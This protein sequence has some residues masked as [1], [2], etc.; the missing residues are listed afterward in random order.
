MFSNRRFLQRAQANTFLASEWCVRLSQSR[1]FARDVARCFWWLPS[2]EDHKSRW[3]LWI[4]L[5]WEKASLL[6]EINRAGKVICVLSACNISQLNVDA[7][8]SLITVPCRMH[9]E[10][11]KRKKDTSIM[12]YNVTRTHEMESAEDLIFLSK[13]IGCR[14]I[15]D[16]NRESWTISQTYVS[17]QIYFSV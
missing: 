10:R 6:L 5:H 12:R 14:L 3:A 15:S 8:N 4:R 9:E 11:P 13:Q 17:W 2:V 1:N 7:P 16:T